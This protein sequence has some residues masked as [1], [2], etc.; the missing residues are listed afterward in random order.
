MENNFEKLKQEQAGINDCCKKLI[1]EYDLKNNPQI[2]PWILNSDSYFLSFEQIF[3]ECIS[4]SF[5][6]NLSGENPKYDI[7]E[8]T[9]LE[10]F[11]NIPN[12][13]FKGSHYWTINCVRFN[14]YDTFVNTYRLE[15]K[16]I[17]VNN[18]ALS[19][20]HDIELEINGKENV[21]YSLLELL[22]LSYPFVDFESPN[23]A[24]LVQKFNEYKQFETF[25]E[26]AD[27][28]GEL[29]N[30]TGNVNLNALVDCWKLA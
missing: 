4:I 1:E 26:T 12:S 15:L 29:L 30:L 18:F 6:A 27:F 24:K 19:Y 25:K 14:D 2:A 10:R 17:L 13:K 7:L 11:Y 22:K 28:F 20:K 5:H 21:Q 16:K 8:D 9:R 3:R 23:Y